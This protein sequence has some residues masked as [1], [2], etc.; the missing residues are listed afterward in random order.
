MD[1]NVSAFVKGGCGCLAAFAVLAVLAVLFGG[2]AHIDL[3]GAACLFVL[4]GAVGLIVLTIYRRG[5]REGGG[6]FD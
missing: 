6:E 4:G 5:Y 2:T 1:D 3:G